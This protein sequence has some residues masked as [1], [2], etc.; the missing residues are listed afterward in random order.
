M[1]L[2][3][4]DIAAIRADL[5]T[6]RDHADLVLTRVV[7]PNATFT[8]A[9]TTL[10]KEITRIESKLLELQ[11]DQLIQDVDWAEST[12]QTLRTEL[13]Q[14][15]G[16]W[17]RE[18]QALA[19]RIEIANSTATRAIAS[20]QH[21]AASSTSEFARAVTAAR[22][23]VSRFNTSAW[24]AFVASSSLM[25]SVIYTGPPQILVG[26]A[27]AFQSLQAALAAI[28]TKLLFQPVAIKVCLLLTKQRLSSAPEMLLRLVDSGRA[29]C[30][31]CVEN[32]AD[33]RSADAA[34][35]LDCRR[36]GESHLGRAAILAA[37]S[38]RRRDCAL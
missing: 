29:R 27:R 13:Q 11:V 28:S 15:S 38:R 17:T 24:R 25:S 6:A 22:A 16:N 37:A 8:I 5:Q 2:R 32:T 35:A 18:S 26:A 21:V 34:P 14:T 33:L 19:A 31:R 9:S 7:S 12:M 3:N 4:G 36:C 30:I 20:V 23:D 1:E 10:Q